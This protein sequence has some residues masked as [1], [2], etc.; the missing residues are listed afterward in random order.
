MTSMVF[1]DLGSARRILMRRNFILI[2]TVL[3]V[4]FASQ[5]AFSD[6]DVTIALD[7]ALPDHLENPGGLL[8]ADC[9][10]DPEGTTPM[11]L[12]I[13]VRGPN[14]ELLF[15]QSFPEMLEYHLEWWLPDG[16]Y[17]GVYHYEVEYLSVEGNNA[18]ARDGF[19]VA[20]QVTGLC[21]LKFE[22]L[23]G[24]G[25]FEDGEPFLPGWEMC[26]TGPGGIEDCEF[27]DEDGLA[28]WFSIPA[29][30]YTICETLQGGY[31][32]T[33]PLCQ[34]I[35]VVEGEIAKL[36]FGNKED[37]VPIQKTTWGAIKNLYE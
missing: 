35:S 5:A 14:E 24:N 26:Y 11:V 37:G 27:T 19:L 6:P 4:L 12:V 36:L 22:D 23:N 3:V 18:F 1:L 30:D 8:I 25:I 28:C 32:N 20:G 7:P 13:R 10:I 33:T 29:G 34:D 2:S 9:V 17:D 15:Q 16:S 31:I 21:A